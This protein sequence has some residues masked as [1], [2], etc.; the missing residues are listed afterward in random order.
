MT[1]AAD[2]PSRY[3]ALNKLGSGG[4]GEVWAVRDR[5]S[6]QQY[7]LKILSKGATAGEMEALV[8]EVSALSG[9]EGLGFPRVLQFGRLA[10]G[11]PYMVRELVQGRSL[12]EMITLARDWQGALKALL[13][14]AQQLTRVHR[15]G[16]FHGDIKP[17]NIIVEPSGRATLVDL[18]LAAP[19]QEGGS[20]VRG[21]TPRYAAPELMQGGALSPRAEVYAFG[22]ALD[23]M[24]QS[25]DLEMEIR[26]DLTKVARR[27][28]H[29]DPTQRYPSADE[30]AS[31]LQR[32]ARISV[33]VA[34]D[35]LALVWP[36]VDL[37]PTSARLLS[38]VNAMQPGSVLSIA[39]DQ[40]SGRSVLLRRL[41]W[42][43]GLNGIALSWVD[44]SALSASAHSD[45]AHG[46]L[47]IKDFL[48]QELAEHTDLNGVRILVDNAEQLDAA[49]VELLLEAKRKGACLIVVGEGPLCKG[50]GVFE[51]PA[52][53]EFAA[54]ELLRRA[55]PSLTATVSKRLIEN[56][57]AAPGRCASWSA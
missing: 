3:K 21:L 10:D 48:N 39:G 28:T 7:A 17:A 6:A 50:A 38:Q 34:G 57:G 54:I 23:E 13:G 11:R 5:P 19:W 30:F 2:F 42:A 35:D 32:A 53:G 41:C 8:R 22:A 29:H 37:E 16:F 18:G 25:F 31:D 36:I 20:D 14:A 52:L 51:V 40:G 4:G 43:L 26:G 9:L 33:D 27:A 47:T 15:A 24:L 46:K 56:A 49:S 1:T 12:Q 55:V 45:S 44:A